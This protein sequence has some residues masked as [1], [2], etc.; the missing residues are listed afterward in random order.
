M[1]ILI[2]RQLWIKYIKSLTTKQNIQNYGI[3]R[4]LT[5]QLPN[6]VK[7]QYKVPQYNGNLDIK[8]VFVSTED[9]WT[10]FTA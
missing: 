6:T 3:N 1:S 5:E 2:E 4:Q 9:W 7:P 8:E 10:N